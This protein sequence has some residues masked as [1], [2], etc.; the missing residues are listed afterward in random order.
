M[1][2]IKTSAQSYDVTAS[3]PFPTPTQPAV[4]DPSLDNLSK[5]TDVAEIFGTCQSLTSPGIVSIWREGSLLGSTNCEQN[6]TFR[7]LVTLIGDNNVLIARSSN[8]TD[9]YGPDSVPVTIVYKLSSS[10]PSLVSNPTLIIS[11]TKPYNVLDENN[12]ANIEITITGGVKPYT[13]V[14]KWGDGTTES[15]AVKNSKTTPLEHIY[16]K[17]GTYKV[18]A[19]ATDN[20]GTTKSYQLI[21]SSILLPAPISSP[22]NSNSPNVENKGLSSS[23]YLR[24]VLFVLLF[25][26]IF[27]TSFLLGRWY[28]YRKIKAELKKQSRVKRTAHKKHKKENI[29]ELSW[30][31]YLLFLTIIVTAGITVVYVNWSKKPAIGK[32]TNSVPIDANVKGSTTTL[33]GLTTSLFSTRV[34]S[35]LQLKTKNEVP[36]SSIIGQYLLLDKEGI[37]GDQLAVTVGIVKNNSIED[38]SPVQLRRSY[39]Q[40]YEEVSPDAGFPKGSLSFVKKSGYEKSTFWVED[41]RYVGVVA[42]GNINYKAQ[43]EN[44]LAVAVN[45][46]QWN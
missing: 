41:G 45:N 27:L 9:N 17:S 26:P 28:E 3:I 18:I 36:S 7:L 30:G 46:W 8:L 29:F 13:L 12:S 6:G 35:N 10:S 37:V 4:I 40:D 42:S 25:V 1:L 22:A 39:P 33:E 19:T 2:P 16:E 31:H 20:I 14:L 43:L 44:S 11:S 38:V 21:I 15:L 34:H 5:D 24:V 23:T 32:I